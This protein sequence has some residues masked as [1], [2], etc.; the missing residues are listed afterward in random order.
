M[1]NTGNGE[2]SEF[3]VT[4]YDF[5]QTIFDLRVIIVNDFLILLVALGKRG[6]ELGTLEPQNL[7]DVEP[8]IQRLREEN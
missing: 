8:I 5:S 1:N 6:E 3:A 4:G 7:F 2:S